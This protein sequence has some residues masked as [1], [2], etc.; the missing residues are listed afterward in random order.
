MR[1]VSV[2]KVQEMQEMVN[3]KVGMA[4]RA[5]VLRATWDVENMKLP[6]PLSANSAVG[7]FPPPPSTN[8]ALPQ[9]N[10]YKLCSFVDRLWELVD[11]ALVDVG[12]AHFV[13]WP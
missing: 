1:R 9:I 2:V 8:N 13:V 7:L 6:V 3:R 10:C 12:R 11:V 5:R 4:Q